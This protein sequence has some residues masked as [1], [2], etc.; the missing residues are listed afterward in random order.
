MSLN[1]TASFLQSP[2]LIHRVDL[3]ARL[4]FDTNHTRIG[5]KVQNQSALPIFIGYGVL[6][7]TPFSPNGPNLPAQNLE[8][9]EMVITAAPTDPEL[10]PLGWYRV[11]PHSLYWEPEYA[12]LGRIWVWSPFGEAQIAAHQWG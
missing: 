4:L 5:F 10:T 9:A 12:H 2:G 11:N 1:R 8:V 6:P 3:G 7:E